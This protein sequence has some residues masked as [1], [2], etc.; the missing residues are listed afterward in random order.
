MLAPE[1][2]SVILKVPNRRIYQWVESGLVHC[3]ETPD[4]SLLV[5]L[6]SLSKVATKLLN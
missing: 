4:A 6:A 1:E 2:A 5:C 3:I